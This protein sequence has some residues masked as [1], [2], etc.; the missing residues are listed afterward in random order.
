MERAGLPQTTSIDV[1]IGD[2]LPGRRLTLIR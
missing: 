2:F 1:L